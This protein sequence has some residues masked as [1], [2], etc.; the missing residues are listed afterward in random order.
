M[1]CNGAR[2]NGDYMKGVIDAGID[3]IRF[4]LIGYNRELYKKW[5]NIDNFDL[6]ISNIKETKKYIEESESNCLISTYHLITDN[7]KIEYEVE[8][9]K[10]NIINIIN[11]QSYIWKM[12][13]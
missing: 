2:L 12:H 10:K 13:N 11:I 4:S 3:F 1:Y 6:I 7:N 5:M 9:Y 8:Q